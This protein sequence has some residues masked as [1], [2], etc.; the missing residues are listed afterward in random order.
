M[1]WELTRA[2]AAG[3]VQELRRRGVEARQ[4]VAEDTDVPLAERVRRVEAEVQRRGREAVILISIHINASGDGSAWRSPSGWSAYTSRG[5][6]RSDILAECLYEAA[7][8]ILQP[9]PKPK[10]KPLPTS[11]EGEESDVDAVRRRA[12]VAAGDYVHEKT[13]LRSVFPFT[14][15]APT[16]AATA[17]VADAPSAPSIRIRRDTS[18]GDSDFEADFYVLRRTSCTAVLTENLFMDNL[19]DADFL[20]T[21]E[22][23]EAIVSL[24]VVGVIAFLSQEL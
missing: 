20:L 5:Q 12:V 16:H 8:K 23:R 6:T 7:R 24:H 11:P 4:L 1:E 10:P 19:G 2:L 17:S 9:E 15:I 3:V 13:P 18:D 14:S 21:Q 22:G